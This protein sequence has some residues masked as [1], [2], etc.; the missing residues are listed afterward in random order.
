MRK[1][2]A[3]VTADWHAADRKWKNRL[4]LSGDSYASIFQIAQLSN[5]M[6]LPV[7][8]AGD[9]FDKR[10]F[11]P[12]VLE[13]VVKNLRLGGMK[14]CYFIQGNHDIAP[15]PWLT[16]TT[17]G[18]AS[19]EFLWVHDCSTARS[20]GESWIDEETGE[21][22]HAALYGLDFKSSTEE[23]QVALDELEEGVRKLNENS[24]TKQ[25]N[26]LMLHQSCEIFMGKLCNSQL[27]EGMISEVFD[28]VIVGD[29]HETHLT[30][31]RSKEGN[32]ELP[33]LSPGSINM[34]T[35]IE[36]SQKSVQI[37]YYE[38]GKVFVDFH[39]LTTRPYKKYEFNV[40]N[41]V[42]KDVY[43]DI[44]PAIT[45]IKNEIKFYENACTKLQK[46]METEYEKELYKNISTPIIYIVYNISNGECADDIEDKFFVNN[47][48]CHLFF[49][50]NY[51]ELETEKYK[52]TIEAID[53]VQD[54]PCQSVLAC[55]P[56]VVDKQKEP[57][58]F[59]L[60]TKLLLSSDPS[61]TLHDYRLNYVLGNGKMGEEND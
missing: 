43:T 9:L 38:N 48:N 31:I 23:L 32:K 53:L 16:A 26:I 52:E 11:L 50:F 27:K 18:H 21:S 25:I 6:D 12:S 61:I 59:D 55:L 36:P 35:I 22:V 47:L 7:I 56:E 1:N 15:T 45:D 39:T 58:V 49:K 40:Q 17:A 60:I 33:L 19:G 24:K 2:L 46:N 54:N 3:I 41:T 8:A 29:F 10:T 42:K 34:Q 30:T 4:T 5:R 44:A 57:Y 20:L 51:A 13:S 14:L 28:F 37:L